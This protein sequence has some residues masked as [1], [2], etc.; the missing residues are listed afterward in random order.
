MEKQRTV[1]TV[2]AN[3]EFSSGLMEAYGRWMGGDTFQNSTIAEEEIPTGQK[4][5]GGSSGAFT[6]AIG[7]VPAVEFDSSTGLPVIDK[8]NADDGS[9]KDPKSS[10][11]GG[12]P[13]TNPQGLKPKYGAQIRQTTLVP[14]NEEKKAKKDYDGDGKVESGKDEYFGSRDKA[15][16]K[17]M[18]KK[19]KKEEN[20]WE[21]AGCCKKCGSKDHVTSECKTAKEEVEAYLWS[22]AEEILTELSEVTETTWFIEGQPWEEL[23][24]EETKELEEEKAKG[25]DGKA[26]W[27][28]YKLA[29]TKEKGGKTVDN[30]V[31]A[32]YEPDGHVIEDTLDSEEW[33]AAAAKQTSRIMDMWKEGYGKG[34]SSK[35]KKMGY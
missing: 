16:K 13:P 12:E 22:Q 3:D 33:K 34:K 2:T 21:A 30:C 19:M 8:K 27:K 32:G 4:Q 25:L 5:G 11:T 6:T 26:C 28:G 24:E 15:I 18:G 35:K 29:G 9:K 7:S 31:K 1:N 10:S 23:T 17:A 20:V 14:A